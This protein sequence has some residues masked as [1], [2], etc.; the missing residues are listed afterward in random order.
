MI[1]LKSLLWTLFRFLLVIILFLVFLVCFVFII[2]RNITQLAKDRVF[3]DVYSIPYNKV[4]LVLGTTKMIGGKPNLFYEARLDATKKLFDAGKIDV[5]L[6]SGDNSTRYYSEPQD[7]KDDL[8]E[9][10]IPDSRIVLD[11]AGFRTLD[12]VVRAEKIFSQKKY[13][14]ITQKFHCERAIYIAD[15][16][17]H[18]AVCYAAS[19]PK[20]I[21]ADRIILREKFARFKAWLDINILK[22]QPKF[23][24]EKVEIPR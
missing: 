20:G 6:V 22:K 11:Y 5:V 3:F 2:D 4:G 23:L 21:L 7:M 24:G 14:I 16:K 12:S 17:H 1:K 13:T 15:K 8:M 19:T 10:G 18:D 9:R